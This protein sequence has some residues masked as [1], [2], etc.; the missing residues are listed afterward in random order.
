MDVFLFEHVRI[1]DLPIKLLEE[2]RALQPDPEL[3]PGA[4]KHSSI[5]RGAH[6]GVMLWKVLDEGVQ[7]VQVTASTHGMI[8]A[9]KIA[10]YLQSLHK[11]GYSKTTLQAVK[12]GK[13]LNPLKYKSPDLN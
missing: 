10:C 1:K 5:V 8:L 7:V 3:V 2:L 4:G 6:K 9:P 11:I 13:W 12:N